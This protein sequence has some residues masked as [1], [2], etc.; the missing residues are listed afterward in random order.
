MTTASDLNVMIKST[1]SLLQ[2]EN[3]FQHGLNLLLEIRRILFR[4]DDPTSQLSQYGKLFDG[5]SE[6]D[7][8]SK[9]NKKLRTIAYGIWHSTRIEDMTMNCLVLNQ[10]QI[11]DRGN[12]FGI[13]INNFRSTGNELNGNEIVDVT[14]QMNISHLLNY[15]KVVWDSTNKNI[16]A[17]SFDDL[18]RKM[19]RVKLDQLLDDGSV[20]KHINAN[21]LIDFWGNKTVAGLLMMPMCRHHI[22]H[23]N[24]NMEAKLKGKNAIIY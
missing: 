13:I 8:N 10:Q 22:V 16:L 20:S 19:N 11:F 12:L 18:I 17:L 7:Y 15:Q 24:E 2:S 1:K 6:S 3:D 4:P 14:R 21:W 9:I 5:L 23:I